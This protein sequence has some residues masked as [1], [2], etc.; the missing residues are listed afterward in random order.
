MIAYFKALYGFAQIS[1]KSK[2]KDGLDNLIAEFDT[3][4]DSKISKK[5]FLSKLKEILANQGVTLNSKSRQVLEDI[6]KKADKDN[7]GKIDKDEIMN[8]MA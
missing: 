3:D 6:F 2:M 1:S 8:A 5:E 7:N 4:G